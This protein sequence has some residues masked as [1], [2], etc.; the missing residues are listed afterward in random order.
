M[1]ELAL[2]FCH[3][4]QSKFLDTASGEQVIKNL[5]FVGKVIYLLSL[6][7]E[8]ASQEGG[9]D[10]EE[11]SE[12]EH[13]EDKGKEEEKEDTEKPPSFLWLI[14]KLSLMA[15]REAAYTPKVPLKVWKRTTK[16][17][18]FFPFYPSF[19]IFSSCYSGR[20]CLS[21]WGRQRWI[22]G[23][24]GWARTSPPWSLLCTES[25]TARTPTKVMIPEK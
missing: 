11:H 2:S 17:M 13:D 6:E 15:K 5:L 20:A 16:K 18:Y 4:L 22:L 24:T 8:T 23:G 3:Q 21:S 12:D 1:R 9:K 10:E 19:H 7:S 25:W 14:K